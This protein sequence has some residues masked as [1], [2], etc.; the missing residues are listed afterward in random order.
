MSK[1]LNFIR[2]EGGVPQSLPGEDHISGL[3]M[4]LPE[5]SSYPTGDDDSFST[6][7][8][9]KAIS[10]IEQAK[11]YGIKPDAA[12]WH[13]KALYYH[14]AEALRINPGI[15]LYVGIFMD[16]ATGFDFEEIKTVQNFADGRIRQMAVYAPTR[17]LASADITLLQGVA[18]SLHNQAMPVQ[19]LYAAT[20][21]SLASI[22]S[23]QASGNNRISVIIGQDG[24]GT[25]STLYTDPG[26]T[27]NEALSMIG[28][29]LG[30]VSLAAVHESIGWVQKFPTGL[31]LPGFIDGSLY[32]STDKAVTEQLDADGF[33]FPVIHPGI[34]GSYMSDSWTMD[35]TTSEFRTIESNR[36]MDKAERGIRTYLTPYLSS[37]L[38]VDAETGKLNPD[39]VA[40][41]ETLAGKQ[42]EDMEAAGELSGYTVEVDPEQNVLS[43][44]TV[45]FVIKPVAV[46]VMRKVN[47]KIGYT[48]KTA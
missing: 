15:T 41:L 20:I 44:S 16:A 30:M 14:I 47:V 26:N 43:T 13:L 36:T 23:L 48:T 37:P 34:N 21:S 31:A 3:L 11:A 2:T 45:E 17:E 46:G 1:E 4:Y 38:Y 7:E 28:A 5:G 19:L 24:G 9:V 42:L 32:R 25:A 8:P 27:T 18:D 29:C 40:F 12:E 39:T 22:P 35:E 10:T 6:A 33:L